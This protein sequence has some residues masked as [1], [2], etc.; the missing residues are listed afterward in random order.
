MGNRNMK[1][2]G[3]LT[4]IFVSLSVFLILGCISQTSESDY[5]YLNQTRDS[6]Y[7]QDLLD[8]GEYSRALQEIYLSLDDLD[9][10]EE[11]HWET[12]FIDALSE[13]LEENPL[14]NRDQFQRD[15]LSL[16]NLQGRAAQHE[17]WQQIYRSQLERSMEEIEYGA[18]S[19]ILLDKIDLNL[20]ESNDLQEMS[21]WFSQGRN[22]ISMVQ[23]LQAMESQGI[24]SEEDLSSYLQTPSMNDL[25]SGTVTIWVDKGIRMEDGVG[26]P[27]RMIG[28]GFFIDPRGYLLTNYHVI[29]SEVDPEYEGYSR[30]FIKR[31]DQEGEKVPARVIG[32]DPILDLALV[33]T[34]MEVPYVFS[35]AE[36]ADWEL[37]TS[38]FAIG[39]PGGLEKTLTT[40]TISARSRNLQ[41]LGVSM[42]VDVPINPGN[43]GGPLLNQDGR[44]IGVVFAGIE[45][46]EGI[47]FAI[48]GFYVK[49]V[50]PRLYQGG[51]VNYS[52]LGAVV[53]KDLDRLIVAYTMSGSAARLGGMEEFDEILEVNHQE[54]SSITQIQNIL[55][56]LQPGTFIPVKILRDGRELELLIPLG[57]RPDYPI[58]L[59]LERDSRENLLL[60]IFGMAVE[61]MNDSRLRPEY[62]I[63]RVFPGSIAD[64]SGIHRNDSLKL[65]K[66]EVN[67][68]EHYVLM[69]FILEGQSAGYM[70][71]VLQIGSW[72]TINSFI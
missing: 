33:K 9:E 40:G 49:E 20:Y 44:V 24:S 8:Q 31:D 14:P 35:F 29:A 67:Q 15:Y 70:E 18:A 19:A 68:E 37:G 63:T 51:Q 41:E 59:A 16:L 61:A 50:L 4:G 10:D 57:S 62:R 47:N 42:Q 17:D 65:I 60:P 27:D 38:I 30:L 13:S 45:D 11:I 69:Q 22:R 28:S 26:L 54:V 2:T 36:E 71:K 1:N 23:I 55:L 39:S 72:F 12:R 43:S 56:P 52:W 66:W 6:L 53:Y 34:E 46:F 48:P 58:S 5:V 7:Y 25:V 3:V 21:Q 32:W 64:D